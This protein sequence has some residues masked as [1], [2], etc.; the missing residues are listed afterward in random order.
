MLKEPSNGMN[1]S[2]KYNTALHCP[3][4]HIHYVCCVQVQTRLSGKLSTRRKLDVKL[5]EIGRELGVRFGEEEFSYDFLTRS[6][7]YF[8]KVGGN[9]RALWWLVIQVLLPRAVSS[10]QSCPPTGTLCEF[11]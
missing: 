6:Y 5:Q 9:M 4:H 1:T 3:L 8:V 10:G 2:K 11:V 7:D